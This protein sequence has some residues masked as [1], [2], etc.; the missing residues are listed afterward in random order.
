MKELN[1][2]P[3]LMN[4]PLIP[5]NFY[6][7]ISSWQHMMCLKRIC[8]MILK[9]MKEI[10]ALWDTKRGNL[11]ISW[12]ISWVKCSLKFSFVLIHYSVNLFSGKF[13]YCEKVSFQTQFIDNKHSLSTSSPFHIQGEKE[14]AFYL[15]EWKG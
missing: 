2:L 15:C 13:I 14:K 7:L 9:D 12:G 10:A 4:L 5:M 11:S 8:L 6:M 1:R 3:A